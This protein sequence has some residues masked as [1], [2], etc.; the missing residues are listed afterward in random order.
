MRYFLALAAA[1]VVSTAVVTAAGGPTIV[2]PGHE[3][4]GSPQMGA[5]TAVLFGNPD[6]TGLY[7]IRLRTGSNWK[8]PP[9]VHPARENVTVISGTFYAGLGRKYDAKK[10]I[11][12]P[13]GSFISLPGGTPHFAM[14]KTPA[15]IEIAGTEP[16]KQ[17]MIK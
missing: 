16:M 10:L 8:F 12:F 5:S 3:K 7:I 9:H 4:W 17:E 1:L 15:V 11:A 6:K 2:M 13:A 14:T